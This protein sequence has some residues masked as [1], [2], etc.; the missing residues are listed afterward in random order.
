MPSRF[1]RNNYDKN[2]T[3]IINLSESPRL[4]VKLTIPFSIWSR[5]TSNTIGKWLKINSNLPSYHSL[6]FRWGTIDIL[7]NDFQ[8]PI[9]IFHFEHQCQGC[10]L[11]FDTSS[12]LRKHK[13]KCE[14]FK[15][16]L[17]KQQS[18]NNTP[19][20]SIN[21]RIYNNNNC[22]NIDNSKTNINNNITINTTSEHLRSFGNENGKYM[23]DDLFFKCINDIEHSLA[24]LIQHRYFNPQ[25]PENQNI[26]AYSQDDIENRIEVFIDNKWRLR[27][28]F[29]VL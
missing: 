26:R 3:K 23:T 7:H 2:Y 13:H 4:T 10:T 22:H 11:C 5:F 24:H 14:Y 15:S 18:D 29:N 27:C 28:T 1:I 17:K 19:T 12:G 16:F 9:D 25:Y 21:Q 20:Q 6:Q 8:Y